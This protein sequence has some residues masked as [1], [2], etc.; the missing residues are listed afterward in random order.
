[1]RLS[2]GELNQ[3]RNHAVLGHG[4]AVQA[5]RARGSAGTKVGFAENMLIAVLRTCSLPCRSSTHLS[6]SEPP[7]RRH[8]AEC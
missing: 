7:R 2:D 5:I 1:M 4:L 3:I 8:A 6:M